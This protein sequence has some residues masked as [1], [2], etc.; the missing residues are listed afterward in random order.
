M[1]PLFGRDL[2]ISEVPVQS[3]NGPQLLL[4]SHYPTEHEEPM[5]SIL[6]LPVEMIV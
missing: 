3:E 4:Q 5:P 2:T 1:S 6:E